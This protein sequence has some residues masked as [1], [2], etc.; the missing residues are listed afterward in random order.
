MSAKSHQ[1]VANERSSAKTLAGIGAISGPGFH[2][3]FVLIS[4]APAPQGR[5]P[6]NF[7]GSELP[8]GPESA[9]GGWAAIPKNF[10]SS[11]LK[12]GVSSGTEAERRPMWAHSVPP[13]RVQGLV[14]DGRAMSC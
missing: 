3:L 9:R 6:F 2:D 7:E 12:A 11:A 14:Q 13:L 10:C 4:S 8:R 5:G 1:H